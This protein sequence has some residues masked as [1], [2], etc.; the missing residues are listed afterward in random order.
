MLEC[1]ISGRSMRIKRKAM[2]GQSVCCWPIRGATLYG[3][4]QALLVEIPCI[5]YVRDFFIPHFFHISPK[6]SSILQTFGKKPLPIKPS[7]DAWLDSI[8]ALI[9]DLY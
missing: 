7:V 4:A 8:I 5:N 9:I 6:F 3:V 2:R 1:R